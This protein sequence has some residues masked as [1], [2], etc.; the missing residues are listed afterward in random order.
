MLKLNVT[1]AL[2][3]EIIAATKKVMI[4]Y[5]LGDSK[6]IDSIE[7]RYKDEVFTLLANDYFTYVVTGRRPK[8]RKVPIRPLID[9]LRRKNIKPAYGQTY[10]TLAFAIQNSIYKS[11][12]NGKDLVS[13]IINVTSDILAEYIAEDLSVS[14]ADELAEVMT[15][16]LK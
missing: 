3:N 10:N 9:W 16:N 13:P 6:L 4:E 1:K 12:I 5:E 14:I 2:I 8:A 7:W 15:F 11:G